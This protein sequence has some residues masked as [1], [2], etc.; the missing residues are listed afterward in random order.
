MDR[1]DD[2]CFSWG[3]CRSSF[4]G[5]TA[6]FR[7]MSVCLLGSNWERVISDSSVR[8]GEIDGVILILVYSIVLRSV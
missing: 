6:G 5:D 1:P 8:C 3:C 7:V 4:N 2:N